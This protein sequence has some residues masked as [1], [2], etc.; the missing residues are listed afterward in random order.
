[1]SMAKGTL[2][3]SYS[4]SAHAFPLTNYYAAVSAKWREGRGQRVGLGMKIFTAGI[5]TKTEMLLMMW[6]IAIGWPQ[7]SITLQ[8]YCV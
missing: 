4:R 7:L 8:H 1:M 3:G 6:T 2:S 5:G